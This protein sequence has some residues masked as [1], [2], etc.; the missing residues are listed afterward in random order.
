VFSELSHYCA[1][2]PR[3]EFAK[4]K[5]KKYGQLVLETR[6]YPV[7]NILY[8]LFIENN[9]K[10]IKYDMFHYLSPIALAY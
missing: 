4:I 1:S 2:I 5:D 9:T 7:F 8:N 3:F 10:S 6:T